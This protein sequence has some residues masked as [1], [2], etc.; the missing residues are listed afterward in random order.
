MYLFEVAAEQKS[1]Q[2]GDHRVIDQVGRPAD[3]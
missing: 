3:V 1:S 2:R